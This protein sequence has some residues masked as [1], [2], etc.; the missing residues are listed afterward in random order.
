MNSHGDELSHH[1]EKEIL[2]TCEKK[3]KNCEREV[4]TID[5]KSYHCFCVMNHLNSLAVLVICSNDKK[6]TDELFNQY[7]ASHMLNIFVYRKTKMSE[8]HYTKLA[9]TDEVTGLLNQ[10]KL[11]EDL[12][13][14]I[15][16]HAQAK[17]NFSLMFIDVDHFKTVNDNFGHIVGSQ[18]L[19]DMGVL[20]TRILRV[21]D[22]IYRYGGD[23]FIVLMPTVDVKTVHDVAERVLKQIKNNQFRIGDAK[24]HQLTVSIGIAEYPTD[25]QTATDIIRFADEMMYKS[26]ESGR[27]KVFH[28]KEVANVDAHI[29]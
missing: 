7:F 10:R 4:I 13:E 29:K 22:K 8:E 16:K 25:A 3:L 23:E 19:H 20:L 27:G 9:M 11:H 12:E 26:K 14:Q 5:K 15:E 2:E 17:E 18:I 1:L 24:T 28:L 6:S 21:S